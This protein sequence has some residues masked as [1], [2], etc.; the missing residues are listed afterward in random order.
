MAL[1]VSGIDHLMGTKTVL[2]SSRKTTRERDFLMRRLFDAFS[3]FDESLQHSMQ[4]SGVPGL[5]RSQSMVMVYLGEGVR[6]PA[7]LA[8]KL[9]VTRQAMHKTILDLE[10]KGYVQLVADPDDRRA[11]IV[12][13]SP[14]G[15]QRH[16]KAKACLT[17]LERELVARLGRATVA[18]LT[19]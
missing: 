12:Q 13:L 9:R 11:K 14:T 19:G 10:D 7:A 4:I 6:R 17:E 5:S 16:S 3:W 1:T 18:A 15:L 8:R 2:Q